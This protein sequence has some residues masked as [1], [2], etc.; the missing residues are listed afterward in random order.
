MKDKAD[1]GLIGLAV[2]GENLIL[3]MADH[4]YTVA[5]YNR[6]TEK[7]DEF[8][9]GDAAGKIGKKLSC[10][11]DFH[12]RTEDHKQ[13]HERSRHPGDRTEHTRVGDQVLH[14]NEFRKTG[15]SG[16]EYAGHI[17]CCEHVYKK[18]ANEHRHGSDYGPTDGFHQQHNHQATEYHFYGQYRIHKL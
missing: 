13:G 18:A 14:L 11:G 9:A 3:N 2:M 5:A 12:E 15:G 4:G 10:L 6:T 7:V 17:G 16:I 1:I 8:L